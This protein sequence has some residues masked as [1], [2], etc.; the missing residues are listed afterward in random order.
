MTVFA[1]SEEAAEV[2]GRFIEQVAVDTEL[3]DKW[4]SSGVAFRMNYSDPEL[5]IVLDATQD[6]PQVRQGKDAADSD[7]AIDLFMTADNG[8]EFWRGELNVP[9]AL[10]RRKIKVQGPVGSLLKLLPAMQPAFGK[11]NDYLRD[12]NFSA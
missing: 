6:P 2:L 4:V 10:A 11:Y 8:H 5:I 7:V 1:T 12:R 9:M 3:K